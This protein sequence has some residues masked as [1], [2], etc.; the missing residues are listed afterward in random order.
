MIFGR[1]KTHQV[2]N[3]LCT[4]CESVRN[5]EGRLQDIS[6]LAIT[7]NWE[8]KDVVRLG[9]HDSVYTEYARIYAHIN[10]KTVKKLL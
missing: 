9:S 7:H 10:A 2:P 4:L 3:R 1:D 8:D 5:L 6:E